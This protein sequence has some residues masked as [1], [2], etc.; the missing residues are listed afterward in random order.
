MSQQATIPAVTPQSA[1]EIACG[2]IL[3][4]L[5]FMFVGLPGSTKT[6]TIERATNFV[7]YDLIVSHPVVKQPEDFGGIPYPNKERTAAD[8][9]AVGDMRKAM[10]VT[11]P[12]VWYLD[13]LGSGVDERVQAAVMQLLLARELDGKKLPDCL[14]LCAASNRR[15][16]RAAVRGILENV[17]SRFVTILEL[18]PSLKEWEDNFAFTDL[19]DTE[20]TICLVGFLRENPNSF[21]D[22]RPSADMDQSPTARTW[23]NVSKIMEAARL[24]GLGSRANEEATIRGAVG[25]AHGT[26]FNAYRQMWTEGVPQAVDGIFADPEAFGI[27]NAKPGVMFGVS[28]ALVHRA[29]VDDAPAVC[30]FAER[31]LE[32]VRGEFT[33]LICR[34]AEK[35]NAALVDT[36]AWTAMLK[37]PVGALL[38]GRDLLDDGDVILP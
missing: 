5:P 10:C 9:L 13:D 1:F 29:T 33:S 24:H 22:F 16:D 20:D 38:N 12:T 15:G 19:P 21:C 7:G 3:A 32:E 2:L 36:L 23:H 6:A 35:R 28:T 27:A 14:T 37:T 4:R 18:L 8:Y 25:H 34:D 30:R 31:C 26:A 11:R 17:K